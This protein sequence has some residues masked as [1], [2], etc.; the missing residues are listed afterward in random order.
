[1]SE[2]PVHQPRSLAFF[3]ALSMFFSM[4][5]VFWSIGDKSAASSW[6]ATIGGLACAGL[7]WMAVAYG[8]P[9]NPRP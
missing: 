9:H 5:T 2:G 1:M 7:V 3:L 4:A 8:K 6:T